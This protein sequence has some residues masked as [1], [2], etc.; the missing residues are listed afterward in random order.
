M[1]IAAP[2][3]RTSH[4]HQRLATM[5]HAHLRGLV[6]VHCGGTCLFENESS[7]SFRNTALRVVCSLALW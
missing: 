6:A 4:S 5:R 3:P 2:I 7:G 1:L